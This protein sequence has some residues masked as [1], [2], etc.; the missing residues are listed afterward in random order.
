MTLF[1][2]C[3]HWSSPWTYP[4]LWNTCW[5]PHIIRTSWSPTVPSLC[6]PVC[7]WTLPSLSPA[8]LKVL[9]L[10]PGLL[11]LLIR[12]PIG[13]SVVPPSDSRNFQRSHRQSDTDTSPTQGNNWQLCLLHSSVSA[14]WCR[15]RSQVCV[16][17]SI[18]LHLVR[19]ALQVVNVSCGPSNSCG[20]FWCPHYKFQGSFS[21]SH[22][23]LRL[24]GLWVSLSQNESVLG[25]DHNPL[26]RWKF[27]QLFSWLDTIRS[28]WTQSPPCPS[29]WSKSSLE[30]V[31]LKWNLLI[32]R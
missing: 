12:Q 5:C 17:P 25:K 22:W 28:A 6:L 14:L 23:S 11:S 10:S 32:S 31:S 29:R 19:K 8:S 1:P 30:T 20:C 26:R 16:A 7:D 4:P 3:N 13:Y 21:G 15:S 27:S 18:R 24:P 9:P 2:S